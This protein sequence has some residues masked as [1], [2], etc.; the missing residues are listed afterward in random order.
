[1]DIRPLDKVHLA[2]SIARP[3]PKSQDKSIV[4]KKS[5]CRK[6][7]LQGNSHKGIL[8]ELMSAMD[9]P[10]NEWKG[11]SLVKALFAHKNWPL[12]S[13]LSGAADED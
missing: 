12:N 7:V 2:I 10:K 9:W 6:S 8:N 3:P 5:A 4:T 1:M 13:F 11:Q